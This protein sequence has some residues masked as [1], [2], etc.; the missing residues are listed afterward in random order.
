MSISREYGENF[1]FYILVIRSLI[2]KDLTVNNI[3]SF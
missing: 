3:L 2:L 1:N